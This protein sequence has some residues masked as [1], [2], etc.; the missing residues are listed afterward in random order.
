[1]LSIESDARFL[2]LALH[3]RC[4]GLVA[5]ANSHYEST[6]NKASEERQLNGSAAENCCRQRGGPNPKR[7]GSPKSC[8]GTL[9]GD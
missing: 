3:E 5:L 9:R 7:K 8:A 4:S 6:R 2:S 1:M